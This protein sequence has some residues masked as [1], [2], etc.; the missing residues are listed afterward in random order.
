MNTDNVN[1]NVPG[2]IEHI[3]H[4]ETHLKFILLQMITKCHFDYI[5]VILSNK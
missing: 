1:L 5:E 3:F 2:K 4:S